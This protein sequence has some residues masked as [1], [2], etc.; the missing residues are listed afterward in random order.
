MSEHGPVAGA[1]RCWRSVLQ[2]GATLVV[3]GRRKHDEMVETVNATS[4]GRKT[5]SGA[6]VAMDVPSPRGTRGESVML[7]DMD[8]GRGTRRGSRILRGSAD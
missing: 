6:W 4:Q 5:P 2:A 7:V 1:R 8:D 3:R